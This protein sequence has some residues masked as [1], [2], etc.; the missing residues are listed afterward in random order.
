MR[1]ECHELRTY[2]RKVQDAQNSELPQTQARWTLT[3]RRRTRWNDLLARRE[4]N[5][6][7]HTRVDKSGRRGAKNIVLTPPLWTVRQLLKY[8]QL[9]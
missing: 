3:P 9:L 1:R 7:E 2:K 8:E 6:P 5:G 4:T